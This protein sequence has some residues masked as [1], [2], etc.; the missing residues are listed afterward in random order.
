LRS[1]S[2]L[3]RD[4]LGTYVRI[5]A[6]DLSSISGAMLAFT[7]AF[8]ANAEKAKAPR[9]DLEEVHVAAMRLAGLARQIVALS[10]REAPKPVRIDLGDALRAMRG[11][12]G[13]VVDERIEVVIE[14]RDPAPAF[15]DP[16]HLE[17]VIFQLVTNAV[18][19]MP[20]G[21]RLTIGVGVERS[22]RLGFVVLSIQD[23]GDG[24]SESTATRAFEPLFTTKK[25]E[26][27]GMGLWIAESI[28]AYAGGTIR[29][30]SAP[31]A[32]TTATVRI[33][34]TR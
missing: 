34:S 16:R 15:I 20:G 28:V 11:V 2:E 29:I 26:G 19:A 30:S 12:L 31:G 8:V 5:F 23:T 22:E 21:G 4:A 27:R 24:M 10:I 3:R 17:Q 6:R 9:E 33:P 18:E 32:G 14:I 1:I 25:G 7:Q 13:E